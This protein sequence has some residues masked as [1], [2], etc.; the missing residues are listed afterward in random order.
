M[1]HESEQPGKRASRWLQW[2]RE[3]LAAAKSKKKAEHKNA[4]QADLDDLEEEAS[5]NQGFV[6]VPADSGPSPKD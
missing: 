2:Q 3:R 4:R 5:K 6:L 1:A